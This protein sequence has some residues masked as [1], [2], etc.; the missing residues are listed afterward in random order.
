MHFCR[1]QPTLRGARGVGLPYNSRAHGFW[2]S[3]G[4]GHVW[5]ACVAGDPIR[6]PLSMHVKG[7]LVFGS[8]S[9]DVFAWGLHEGLGGT[10]VP[11]DE[12]ISGRSE[13]PCCGGWSH[14]RRGVCGRWVGSYSVRRVKTHTCQG[15]W[16]RRLTGAHPRFG[17]TKLGTRSS[18]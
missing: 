17:N 5:I 10:S 7:M 1:L 14:R 12:N 13:A 11:R 3:I 15:T 18:S 4:V 8:S 2:G 9:G 16:R 6:A